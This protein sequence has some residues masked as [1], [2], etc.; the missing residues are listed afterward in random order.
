[1]ARKPGP[2]RLAGTYCGGQEHPQPP[3][4]FVTKG[5]PL[6]AAPVW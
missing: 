3:Q 4:R 2:D 5:S 6:S 1:V